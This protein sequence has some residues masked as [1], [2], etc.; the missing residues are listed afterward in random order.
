MSWELTI[1]GRRGVGYGGEKWSY[2]GSM[3]G[4]GWVGDEEREGWRERTEVGWGGWLK[5]ITL[6]L[7]TCVWLS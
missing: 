1:V 3:L 7:P 5:P 2:D 4:K 6:S